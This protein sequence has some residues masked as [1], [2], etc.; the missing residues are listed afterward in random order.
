[1]KPLAHA[2]LRQYGT[3]LTGKADD[4]AAVDVFE[5][6]MQLAPLDYD[7]GLATDTR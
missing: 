6:A 7:S 2:F 3:V 4:E 1:M 5:E